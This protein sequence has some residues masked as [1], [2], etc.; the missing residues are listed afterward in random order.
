VRSRLECTDNRDVEQARTCS[1]NDTPLT[2]SYNVVFI[3]TFSDGLKWA[4]RVPGNGTVFTDLDVQRMNSVYG[5]MTYLRAKVP[6]LKIPE[7]FAWKT[8]TDDIGVPYAFI[9]FVEGKPLDEQWSDESWVTEDKRLKVL[10][11]L[12]RMTAGLHNL[13]FDKIGALAFDAHGQYDSV[14]HIEAVVDVNIDGVADCFTEST[15]G[16][17]FDT[18]EEYLRDDW[19]DLSGCAD[20]RRA[21]LAIMEIALETIP[22]DMAGDGYFTLS[23]PDYNYQNIFV[24][25]DA[26]VTGIIDWDGIQTAPRGLGCARYP[27]WITRDW[28]PGMYGYGVSGCRNEDSPEEL[29]RYRQHYA[30]EFEKHNLPGYNPNETKLSHILEAIQIGLNDRMCR[31]YIAI[32]LLGHAFRPEAPF[33]FVEFADEI[34]ANSEEVEGM[35]VQIRAAFQKMWFA[36]WETALPEAKVGNN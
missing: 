22:A 17:P 33:T 12:A 29:S 36:E 20:W 28:D 30:A 19:D 7:V 3:L 10:A 9:Q 6:T 27:S 35:K 25:D 2:G 26:K 14:S 31:A 34:E 18:T 13:Q 23:H 21:D 8:T 24:D 1:V 5:T 11:Q 32:K 16:G 4:V 15:S